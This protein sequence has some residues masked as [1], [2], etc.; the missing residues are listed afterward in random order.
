MMFCFIKLN[1]VFLSSHK[2]QVLRKIQ[3]YKSVDSTPLPLV[4]ALSS[5]EGLW[6][7]E[8][9]LRE[10]RLLHDKKTPSRNSP[11]G[12]LVFMEAG[13]WK[14][15]FRAEMICCPHRMRAFHGAALS[16][17]VAAGE[18]TEDHARQVSPGVDNHLMKAV[19][20]GH[21]KPPR[22][23]SALPRKVGQVS[24]SVQSASFCLYRSIT[25]YKHLASCIWCLLLF[26]RQ[27]VS[28]SFAIL[29]T[30]TRQAPLSMAFPRQGHWSGLPLPSP[31][32]L[33]DPGIKP[34]SPA[35]EADS[36]PLRPLQSATFDV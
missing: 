12:C 23:Y 17:S 36:L 30:V 14:A 10:D 1:G 3:R 29:W 32:D 31:G 13:R 28:D 16:A 26:S 7:M 21:G 6:E 15:I 11:F 18:L 33:P 34:A 19:T 25:W 20:E 8:N 4:N 9:I 35:L 22:N 27:V 5:W 2:C 24:T